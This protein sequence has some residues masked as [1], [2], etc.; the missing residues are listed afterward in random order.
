MRTR[1][2]RPFDRPMQGFTIRVASFGDH[3]LRGRMLKLIAAATMPIVAL[4]SLASWRCRSGE[5]V[6]TDS[7]QPSSDTMCQTERREQSP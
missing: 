4:H 6:Q 1:N 3:P 7:T 5:P 2:T